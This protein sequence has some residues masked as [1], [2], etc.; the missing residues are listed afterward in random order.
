[1][2]RNVFEEF[3]HKFREYTNFGDNLSCQATEIIKEY[4]FDKRDEGMETKT[5]EFM[6]PDDFLYEH[7]VSFMDY[8][9]ME[10]ALV[11]H[12]VIGFRREFDTITVIDDEYETHFIGDILIENL[13][14]IICMVNEWHDSCNKKSRNK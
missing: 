13:V 14:S 8:N 10:S 9:P 5:I 3:F 12:L 7:P 1:M 11:H 6:F 2:K 4:I